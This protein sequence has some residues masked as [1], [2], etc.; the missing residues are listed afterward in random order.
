MFFLESPHFQYLKLSHN[1][2][3]FKP[4][5][6]HSLKKEPQAGLKCP[7]RFLVL[8][9]LIKLTILPKVNNFLDFSWA[10]FFGVTFQNT[11]FVSVLQYVVSYHL[12]SFSSVG[13]GL[14]PVALEPHAALLPLCSSSLWL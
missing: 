9:S 3:L 12:I 11:L 13:R 14:Q 2:L 7:V 1:E 10:E 5:F 8:K 6:S 4:P